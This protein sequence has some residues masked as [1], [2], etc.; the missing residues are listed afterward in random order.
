MSHQIITPFFW[1]DGQAAAAARFHAEVFGGRVIDEA[2]YTEAGHDVHG[3]SD[4][5]VMV[6][7]CDI[8]GYRLIGLNGGPAFRPSP[9]I[10]LFVQLPDRD[11]A[12]RIWTALSDGGTALMP[13]DAYD[14]SP[15]YGWCN[16]RYGVSWQIMFDAEGTATQPVTPMLAFTGAVTGRAAEALGF[17]ASVFP[18]SAVEM[19]VPYPAGASEPAGSIVQGRAVLAGGR[20]IAMDAGRNHDFGFD[21]GVSLVVNCA[22]QAEVDHYWD[23]FVEGGGSHGRCGWLKDRFGV[24]WQVVPKPVTDI[25]AG[26]DRKA[27]SRAMDAVMG[28]EKIDIATVLRASLGE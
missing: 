1:H 17:Y 13:F 16:D 6:A 4:G 20:M 23:R 12:E 27:A 9:A 24:S 19:T 5:E 3:Q 25:L 8:L 22:D 21:E 14:W 15:A 2:R 18:G 28:M 26:P 10:S 11:E 7:E